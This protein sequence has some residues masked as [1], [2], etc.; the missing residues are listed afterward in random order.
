MRIVLIN[1]PGWQKGSINL[2]LSYLGAKLLADKHEV[3]IFD[4][5]ASEMTSEAIAEKVKKLAPQVIGFSIKTA[6]VRPAIMI[7]AAIK[8]I[9][10]E[11]VHVAGGPHI[12]LMYE[13]FLKESPDFEYA[14]LG[15]ADNSFPEFINQLKNSSE[16]S[17]IPGLV[18][19]KD[20]KLVVT[21]RKLVEELDEL[22]FPDHD[23]I[24][25]F[26]S[27]DFRYP[28]ITSRG[29]PYLCIYCCVGIVSSRKW[30]AR[31]VENIISELQYA[32]EHYGIKTF[33]IL[34]D[35]FTLKLDR[36]KE[37]CRA[38]IKKKLKL[39]WYCHNGIRADKLDL[40]LT[41]LMK[42]AGCTSVA[43]GIESGD[44]KV[45]NS[46]KKGEKLS[47]IVAGV[48]LIQKA[49]MRVVGYFIIGLPG[50]TAL[51]TN[52]TI[53]F[54]K[55]LNLDNYMFG[56]L[57]PYPGT[58]AYDLVKKDG[59]I[60]L[61]IKDTYHFSEVI[62][63]PIE[64]PYFTSREIEEA[65]YHATYYGLYSVKEI[66][67][68]K[69]KR[70]PEKVLYINFSFDFGFLVVLN[71]VFEEVSVDLFTSQF[72]SDWAFANKRKYGLNELFIYKDKFSRFKQVIE[73]IKFTLSFRKKEYDV[74]F[75]N[76][77]T[78]RLFL[79]VAMLLTGAKLFYIESEQGKYIKKPVI[80]EHLK[81]IF[82]K[83]NPLKLFPFAFAVVFYLIMRF[84]ALFFAVFLYF[85]RSGKK[86][87]FGKGEPVLEEIDGK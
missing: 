53:K 3:R 55:G 51:T 16:L 33:E 24:D 27:E 69:T 68:K 86:V 58:E 2:G 46:I 40:E 54:I 11:A 39:A 4:V 18:Y 6:T 48:K 67:N 7:S 52:N 30:R 71:K 61:D 36:A 75:Y 77:S 20:G 34:D 74:V 9:Y 81:M 32:K 28:L 41:K 66:F 78:R 85:K 17:Q 15:E 60:L 35:N 31:S 84:V 83:T 8:K 65:Y 87:I 5:N 12:T 29:C 72:K 80:K 76:G 57:T 19:K 38:L 73:F 14:F 47:D 1:P 37:L 62:K 59:K 63:S 10:Q 43:L 50:D 82:K 64:Y 45:F 70:Y 13:E 23:I 25:T 79:P 22:P 56:V 49:G 21:E 42:K 44:E 26:V